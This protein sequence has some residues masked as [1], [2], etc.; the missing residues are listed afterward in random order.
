MIDALGG[1]NGSALIQ[2]RNERAMAVFDKQRSE[3]RRRI[4][5]FYGAAHMPDFENRLRQRGFE[6]D[7]TRWF[8]AWLL[9]DA[10]R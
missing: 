1:E 7:E 10:T 8:D 6:P 5:I 4:G 2:A 9:N 3:G